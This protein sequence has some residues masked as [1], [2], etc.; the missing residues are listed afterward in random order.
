MRVGESP[1]SNGPLAAIAPRCTNRRFAL[2][3]AFTP[4]CS[5]TH[6]PGYN[7]LTPVLKQH[8]VDEVLCISVNDAFVMN[9]WQE[10]QNAS[11]IT[12]MPDGN[13]DFSSGM[14]ML[15]SKNDLGF[16]G[17]VAIDIVMSLKPM[18]FFV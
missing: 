5:S 7:Q 14:G 11:N 6:V 4:T 15:V 18:T 16:G 2:P 3:G 13:G 1:R 10:Q 9:Q 17:Y 8:G 12:F